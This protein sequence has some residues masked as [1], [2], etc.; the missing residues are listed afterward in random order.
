MNNESQIIGSIDIE[1]SQEEQFVIKSLLTAALAFSLPLYLLILI[2]TDDPI[3]KPNE[4][5][6]QSNREKIVIRRL[7]GMNF[8]P[9]QLQQITSTEALLKDLIMSADI[10]ENDW[11]QGLYLRVCTYET[12]SNSSMKSVLK[13]DEYTSWPEFAFRKVSD[14][15]ASKYHKAYLDFFCNYEEK[16]PYPPLLSKLAG[17]LKY[18]PRGDGS[19]MLNYTIAVGDEFEVEFMAIDSFSH[20]D[21]FDIVS[22][23]S[24]YLSLKGLQEH[25]IRKLAQRIAPIEGKEPESEPASDTIYLLAD[26]L[27]KN[28]T[29]KLDFELKGEGNPVEQFLFNDM[30]GHCQLF[31]AG[32]VAL[33]RA[34]GIPARVGVGY[35]TDYH[36]KGKYLITSGMA[37]AWPEILTRKGWKIFE[38]KPKKYE[39]QPLIKAQVEFPTDEQ[40]QN[41]KQQQMQA[42]RL[43]AGDGNDSGSIFDDNPLGP[44]INGDM[45]R[46]KARNS[47]SGSY[48]S[49]G[50]LSSGRPGSIIKNEA[51]ERE[52]LEKVT[53]HNIKRLVRFTLNFLFI[54]LI[55]FFLFKYAEEFLKWLIK[56]MKKGEKEE[57]TE[58]EFEE[59]KTEEF[60]QLVNKLENV[61]LTGQDLAEVF[62]KFTGIM[63]ARSKFVRAEHET[64]HEYFEKI[65][66][67][68]GLRPAIGLTA[69]SFLESEVYGNKKVAKSDF[70]KFCEFLKGILAKTEIH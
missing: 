56:L 9:A 11:N 36:K 10:Q 61:E 37:H 40:L 35:Y 26:F 30:K 18:S 20:E 43:I 6:G 54:G 3:F 57:K 1:E 46:L 55:I 22:K 64:A 68:L 38:I 50:F 33:C 70:E 39:L 48:S 41:H 4:S 32:F 65:C 14:H 53:Q 19:I 67:E 69:A 49:E 47:T 25:R 66:L 63:A 62:D 12:F 5:H 29:Y 27:E 34:R 59:Q 2:Y 23:S 44:A 21:K 51:R 60:L 17:P 52:Y 58:K 28:G 45:P 13:R 15:D 16:L 7:A 8:A 31:A 24:P 42:A